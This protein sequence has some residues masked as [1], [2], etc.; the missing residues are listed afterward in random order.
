MID[1]NEEKWGQHSL[2]RGSPTL[3]WHESV[4]VQANERGE[5]RKGTKEHGELRAHHSSEAGV[6]LMWLR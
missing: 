2:W 6:R 5:R 3:E 4:V 1:V